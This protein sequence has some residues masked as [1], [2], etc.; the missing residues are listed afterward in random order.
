M[1]SIAIWPLLLAVV[2]F[3]D[4]DELPARR[5]IGTEVI[6]R[7]GAGEESVEFTMA[8]FEVQLYLRIDQA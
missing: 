3:L 7:F 1:N 6:Q 8:R 2:A 4:G 5:S